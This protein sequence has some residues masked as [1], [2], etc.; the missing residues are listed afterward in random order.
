MNFNKH[1]LPHLLFLALDV[2]LFLSWLSF[3]FWVVHCL[4]TL[5]LRLIYRSISFLICACGTVLSLG[6]FSRDSDTLTCVH[7]TKPH[8]ALSIFTLNFIFIFCS[9][10]ISAMVPFV[11]HWGFASISGFHHKF[12]WHFSCG[13]TC[14][15]MVL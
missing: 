12:E 11:R 15:I 2:K 3:Y 7:P 13:Y 14:F 4:F 5:M 10:Q 6:S 1:I 9:S 8:V